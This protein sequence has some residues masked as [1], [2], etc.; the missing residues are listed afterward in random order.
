MVLVR[1]GV[2][3]GGG[4]ERGRFVGSQRNVGRSSRRDRRAVGNDDVG[5][6]LVDQKIKRTEDAVTDARNCVGVCNSQHVGVR[7]QGQDSVGRCG[8]LRC[9]QGPCR[10]CGGGETAD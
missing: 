6:A 1:G 5:A 2:G 9:V 7:W 8:G 10:G 3:G 4:D